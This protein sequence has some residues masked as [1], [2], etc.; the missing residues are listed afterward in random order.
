MHGPQVLASGAAEGG[1]FVGAINHGHYLRFNA[2]PLDRVRRIR[3]RV[4]SAGAGGSIEIRL[5]QP[6]GE[7][8]ATVPVEVNGQWEQFYEKTTEIPETKGR[9]DVFIRFVHPQNAGGLMNLDSLEFQ[10]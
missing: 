5:D 9:H 1:K 8:M 4:A 3:L 6:E 2:I 7:L 10:P